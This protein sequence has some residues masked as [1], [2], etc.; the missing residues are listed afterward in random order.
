M[1]NIDYIE[2]SKNLAKLM[3]VIEIAKKIHSTI[4][5]DEI[6]KN[7]LEICVKELETEGGTI[8]FLDSKNKILESRYIISPI[9]IKKISLKIGEGIAGYVAKTGKPVIIKETKEDE[10]FNKSI[11]EEI[12]YK[13][14]SI[15]CYPLKDSKNEIIG[16]IELVNKKNGE[17]GEDDLSL[18]NEVSTFISL[19]IKNAY[20]YKE[21]IIK[22]RLSYEINMA[23][24]IQKKILPKEEPFLEGY[25][26]KTYFQPCYETAGDF[27]QFYNLKDGLLI[28]LV[29]VSGKGVPAAMVAN[30]IYSYIKIKSQENFQLKDLASGLSEFLYEILEGD[31]YATGIMIKI[32]KDGK[33]KYLN[34][35]NPPL[36]LISENGEYFKESTSSPFGIL[37]NLPFFEKE[38][39]VYKNDL[40]FIYSD[41]FTET[42]NEKEEEFGKNRLMDILKTNKDKDLNSIISLLNEEIKN[43]QGNLPNLDDKTIIAIKKL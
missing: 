12:K 17:F 35:G 19:S 39:E 33:I 31:K 40:I 38:I 13:T 32:Q 21:S 36:I 16:C 8:F 4:E 14:R 43:F 26:I 23:R 25:K 10:R 29:D 37:P 28:F 34:A 9:P 20:Y 6:L 11:D 22:E 27:F 30:S 15:I 5:L 2:I 41:G 3:Q 24:E 1:D 7:F 42:Q 18:L